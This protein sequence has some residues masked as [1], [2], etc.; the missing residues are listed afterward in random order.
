[1]P[2]ATNSSTSFSELFLQIFEGK[3][4]EIPPKLWAQP[5]FK[6]INKKEGHLRDAQEL[7]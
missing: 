6:L 5:W 4:E 1:V 3:F 2:N 7:G